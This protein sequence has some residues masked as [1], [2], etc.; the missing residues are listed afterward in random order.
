MSNHCSLGMASVQPAKADIQDLAAR[1]SETADE[2]RSN[3]NLKAA[4]YSIPV[5]GLIFLTFTDSRFT[6]PEGELKDKATARR[7]VGKTAQQAKSD[8]YL[9]QH[10]TFS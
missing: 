8:H 4:E 2:L 10:A 7:A 3:S 5:P 1:L 9:T 6:T